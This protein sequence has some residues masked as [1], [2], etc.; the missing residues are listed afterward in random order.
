MKKIF[1][2]SWIAFAVV[3]FGVESNAHALAPQV[4]SNQPASASNLYRCAEGALFH[5]LDE[6]KLSQ[7]YEYLHADL[8]KEDEH[9]PER[10]EDI[11][12]DPYG[13]LSFVLSGKMGASEKVN[14]PILGGITIHF[15]HKENENITCTIAEKG[16]LALVELHY[17]QPNDAGQKIIANAIINR[18]VKP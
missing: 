6:L 9:N 18:L 17:D 4:I 15:S 5:A 16:P 8:D 14:Q 7:G 10:I 3:T 11:A 12:L 13:R 1:I 2:L